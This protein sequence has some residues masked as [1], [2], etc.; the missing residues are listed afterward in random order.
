MMHQEHASNLVLY[1][2]A[3]CSRVAEHNNQQFPSQVDYRS[4]KDQLAAYSKPPMHRKAYTS[5]ISA[6]ANNKEVRRRQLALH[7]VDA[8]MKSDRT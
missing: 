6:L 5:A 4:R 7:E 8:L 3:G 1:R 2:H